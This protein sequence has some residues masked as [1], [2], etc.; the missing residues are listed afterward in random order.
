MD[1][2]H[3]EL[4]MG[5]DDRL[6]SVPGGE[7]DLNVAVRAVDDPLI[8]RFRADSEASGTDGTRLLDDDLARVT[9]QDLATHPPG[10]D[11]NRAASPSAIVGWVRMASRNAV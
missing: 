1:A 11:E 2:A 5:A 9:R 3:E 6:V 4:A 10:T 7:R 8:G